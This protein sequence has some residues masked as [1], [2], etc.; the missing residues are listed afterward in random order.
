M[1]VLGYLML[2]VCGVLVVWGL[3]VEGADII[4]DLRRWIK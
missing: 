4:K 1:L 3:C 2:I